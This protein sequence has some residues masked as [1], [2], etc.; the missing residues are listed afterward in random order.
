MTDL[1]RPRLSWTS[2][3]L[4]R[5][6]VVTVCLGLAAA[7]L[8]FL[9]DSLIYRFGTPGELGPTLWNKQAWYWIHTLLA[10][11]TLL[12]AP[13]QFSRTIRSRW[14]RFH[15]WTGRAYI[16]GA[17]IAAC[18]AVVLAVSTDNLGGRMPLVMLAGL[19]FFFTACAWITAARRDIVNHRLFMLRSVNCALA[20]VWI[21]GLF[22]VPDQVLFPYIADRA[23]IDASREWIT[24]TIPILLM[25]AWITWLPQVRGVRRR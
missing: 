3:S 6:A 4:A 23:I 18:I 10:V 9:I 22:L 12:L 7:T 14:P 17:L 24:A 20:F 8:L 19:W 5:V 21:R 16:V 2:R 25:E 1:P 13:I 11:P 15:R